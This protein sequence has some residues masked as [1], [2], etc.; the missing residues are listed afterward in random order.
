MRPTPRPQ[1][2][3]V[4]VLAG[5]ALSAAA[6]ADVALSMPDHG[7]HPGER[8]RADVE[9]ATEAQRARA[10]ELLAAVHAAARRNLPSYRSARRAGYARSRLSV[11][12]RDGTRKLTLHLNRREFYD[13]GRLVDPERPES[14]VYWRRA[15][16][17]PVLA[18]VMF[19]APRL[20]VPDLGAGPITSWHAHT[21]CVSRRAFRRDPSRR[22]MGVKCPRGQVARFGV[23]SMLH[24]WL[25]DDIASAFAD[26]PSVATLSAAFGRG[27]PGAELHPDERPEA[28]R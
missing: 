11:R 2:L 6:A 14:L 3:V 22:A 18:A 19:R 17:A 10:G 7:D 5:L 15:R 27:L 28:M 20:A 8:E 12:N 1:R 23:T 26:Q 25:L 16:G 13:D 9:G 24:V 21:K 4:L